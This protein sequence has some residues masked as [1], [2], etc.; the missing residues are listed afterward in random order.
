[1][2]NEAVHLFRR[3]PTKLIDSWS[4]VCVLNGCSHAGLISQAWQIFEKIPI[5]AKSDLIYTTMVI[6]FREILVFH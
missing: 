5:E 6:Q 3:M 1:M 4:Y 2:G